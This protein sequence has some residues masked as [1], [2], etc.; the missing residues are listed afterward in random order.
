MWVDFYLDLDE[1]VLSNLTGFSI[2]DVD[3]GSNMVLTLR[4]DDNLGKFSLASVSGLTFS[5]G[6]GIGDLKVCLFFAF[7]L[8]CF[9]V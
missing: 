9:L 6:D 5:E 1:D 3:G 2:A 8:S 4:T 7:L